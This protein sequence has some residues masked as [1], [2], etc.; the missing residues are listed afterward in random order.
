MNTKKKLLSS[1]ELDKFCTEFNLKIELEKPFI[2]LDGFIINII[3][4]EKVIK[5]GTVEDIKDYEKVAGTILNK[6]SQSY[7]K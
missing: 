6:L 1:D 4:N 7:P 5:S 3:E 2:N